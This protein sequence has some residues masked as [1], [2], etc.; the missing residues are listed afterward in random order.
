VVAMLLVAA[1]ARPGVRSNSSR[2]SA[3]MMAV[4]RTKMGGMVRADA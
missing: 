4:Y 3:R 1:R 2:A